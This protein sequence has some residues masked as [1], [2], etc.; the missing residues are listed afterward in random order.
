M[1][2]WITSALFCPRSAKD[3]PHR[4]IQ[5]VQQILQLASY[6]T[7]L[8]ASG[9]GKPTRKCRGTILNPPS[10]ASLSAQGPPKF[11]LRL[12]ASKGVGD[13]WGVLALYQ[14]VPWPLLS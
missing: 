1:S 12:G 3:G 8:S 13:F 7:P 14:S 2:V 11:T 4:Q 6:H 9:E 10:E 5:G